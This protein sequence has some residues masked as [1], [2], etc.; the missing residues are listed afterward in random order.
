M[1]FLLWYTASNSTKLFQSSA[2]SHIPR[3][4]L[5][6]ICCHW[7]IEPTHTSV[8]YSGFFVASWASV[9]FPILPLFIQLMGRLLFLKLLYFIAHSALQ[10][11]AHQVIIANSFVEIFSLISLS[12]LPDTWL[13]LWWPTIFRWQISSWKKLS[14][15]PNAIWPV[16]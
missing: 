8:L 7:S 10:H 6:R 16:I 4:R 5:L 3:I 15:F 13:M 14:N 2:S 12:K 11:Q 1:C 9:F